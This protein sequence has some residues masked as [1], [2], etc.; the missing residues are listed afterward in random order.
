VA[1]KLGELVA[2]LK[3]DN[4]QLDAGLD[5]G[6]RKAQATG[7]GMEADAKATGEGMARGLGA[8]GARGGEQFVRGADGRLRD[9]RGKFVSAG[10]ALGEGVGDGVSSGVRGAVTAFAGLA[11]A[12]GRVAGPIGGISGAIFAIGSAAAFAAPLVGVLGGAL[13][14]LPGLMAGLGAVTGVLGLGFMGLGDHFK[15]AAGGSAGGKMVDTT[16]Q[17]L[18]AERRLRDAH[19]EVTES[20]IALT[21]ARDKAVE[22]LADIARAEDRAREAAE[23]RTRQLNGYRLD[24]ER[25]TLRVKEAQDAYN[26]ALRQPWNPDG[27]KSAE[28]AVREAQQALEEAKDSTQDLAKEDAEAKAKG[29]AGSDEVKQAQERHQAALDEVVAARR[30]ERAAVEGVQDAEH[31]LSEARKPQGG[32]GGGGGAGQ[33]LTKLAPAAAAAVAAIKSLKPAFEALRLDIQER[34][35]KG[36]GDRIKDIA[37][38]WFP[39]LHDRLGAIASTI[40]EVFHVFAAS[41]TKPQF[42][43]DISASLETF[44]GLLGRVGKALAGPFVDAFGRLARAAGPFITVL[45]DELGGLIEDFSAWIKKADESGA[46]TDFFERA[47]DSLH[48]IFTIGRTVVA[49]VVEIMSAIFDS[50]DK[51]DPL[52]AFQGALDKVRAWL[53][54]PEN[55]KK[56]T[57]F[58]SDL[59]TWIGQAIKLF[60]ALSPV[61]GVVFAAFQSGAQVGAMWMALFAAAIGKIGD[62]ISWVGKNAPK[63]WGAVKDAAGKAKDWV[64]T[65]WNQLVSWFSGIGNRIGRAVSGMWNGIKSTFKDAI[66]WVI[67]KW[68]SLRFGVPQINA[69]GQSVGGGTI[70]VPPVPYLAKGA[71]VT[72]PTLAMVGEGPEPEGVLPLSKLDAL[73]AGGGR[74]NR[75]HITGDGSDAADLVLALLRTAVKA[76]GGDVQVVVGQSY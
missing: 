76:R 20:Q 27:I 46:L 30:R 72:R 18:Q 24:E 29:I 47:A 37:A 4:R 68:N 70:G 15:K 56:I 6:R 28:L 71:V 62:A 34:L 55:K 65:K 10:R 32:G 14:A 22:T 9:S 73:L 69:F 13:G 67:G 8:G 23:D 52:A 48:Q 40:N 42:L 16:Y 26:L 61:I 41:I 50:A 33:E 36:V 49:I 38:V 64:V 5:A 17:I 44:D 2:I 60:E 59:T 1:L 39:L 11:A 51:K 66:N 21:R 19:E 7:A 58:F 54:D 75:L 43:E 3:T 12:A 74:A 53:A 57:D 45:G 35:F 31:A 25:A 63:W